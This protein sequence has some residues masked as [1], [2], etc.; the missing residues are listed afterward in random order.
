MNK[1]SVNPFSPVYSEFSANL[2]EVLCSLS[3]A[4][5]CLSNTQTMHSKRVAMM[6][7][8]C[9]QQM[10]W[11]KNQRDT[12]FELGLLHDIAI[13]HSL[14]T[15]APN[16]ESHLG[17]NNRSSIKGYQLLHEIPSLKHLAWPI[18]HICTD[19][20]ELENEDLPDSIKLMANL[21]QLC[22]FI[23]LQVGSIGSSEIL[24]YTNNFVAQ[25]R[26]FSGS[27]FSPLLIESFTVIARDHSFWLGLHPH[28]VDY[29]IKSYT[30][31]RQY[32]TLSIN[33]FSEL[34]LLFSHL[35]DTKSHFTA[36]HSAGVGLL[37]RYLAELKEL[38][39]L[40]CEKLQIAGYLHDLGKLKINNTLLDKKG[41]Y[42]Q[43]EIEGMSLHVEA[44]LA[45]LSPIS[46]IIDILQWIHFHHERLDGSGYPSQPDE[47]VISV[48]ARILAISDTFQAL[49][50]ERAH[51][52]AFSKL[53][54]LHELNTLASSSKLDEDIISLLCN[55]F[56]QCYEL[57][58][59]ITRLPNWWVH[60]R[61]EHLEGA[62]TV[63]RD[64]I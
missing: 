60:K 10:N 18:L 31:S 14:P 3:I 23:D 32:E 58:S 48:E 13:Q 29:F 6:A 15:D 49:T 27:K 28:V 44:S 21:I 37:A 30:P 8:R 22:D 46:G 20:T 40:T 36:Q 25:V 62:E 9:A 43:A 26:E 34:A 16:N 39:L 5:D 51:R 47:Q 55:N 1:D 59:N 52:D 53:D 61:T 11:D 24:A 42:D 41:I 57:A 19:W 45:I 17:N 54:I 38:P 50:Q 4:I 7:V 2:Y 64:L 35:V 12:L 63:V 56:S 33:E